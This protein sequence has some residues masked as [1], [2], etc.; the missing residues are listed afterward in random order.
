MGRG[1]HA[2]VQRPLCAGIKG[3]GDGPGRMRAGG[4]RA[5]GLPDS[6]GISGLQKRARPGLH[7]LARSKG[8]MRLGN[9]CGQGFGRHGG[10][11]A[12]RGT[13]M[14]CVWRPPKQGVG[15]PTR[16]LARAAAERASPFW[17]V[18]HRCC[19]RQAHGWRAAGPEAG[20][21]GRQLT[22]QAR[23]MGSGQTWRAAARGRLGPEG[24]NSLSRAPGRPH[25]R[26]ARRTGRARGK[27]GRSP[28]A[29]RVLTGAG[30][31][32]RRSR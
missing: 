7:A 13:P 16:G 1:A 9:G 3:G 28:R 10:L 20:A 17:V 11:D 2:R 6:C 21:A 5:P 31:S 27:T 25:R 30:G 24:C 19:M 8:R 26:A 14:P 4:R 29:E 22:W 23:G 32:R 12:A 15:A 18:R